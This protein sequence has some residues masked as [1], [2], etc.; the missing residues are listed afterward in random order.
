M[1]W[2]ERTY[3]WVRLNNSNAAWRQWGHDDYGKKYERR[4]KELKKIPGLKIHPLPSMALAREEREKVPKWAQMLVSCRKAHLSMLMNTFI[5]FGVESYGYFVWERVA[6][7]KKGE[8][9]KMEAGKRLK[10]GTWYGF[11]T[12]AVS[13][14]TAVA[15]RHRWTCSLEGFSKLIE[16]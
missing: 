5:R 1:D 14:I 4:V 13:K 11:W 9:R 15:G 16:L 8:K 2:R 7:P 6:E 12:A 3:Y 10:L